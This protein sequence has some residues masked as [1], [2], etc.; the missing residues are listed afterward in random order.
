MNVAQS[1]Q[2]MVDTLLKNQGLQ[3]TVDEASKQLSK[4]LWLFDLN[5]RFL[6]VPNSV[7]PVPEQIA[8]SFQQGTMP[9]EG[10][11][12]IHAE[13]IPDKLWEDSAPV[14]YYNNTL[15]A[16]LMVLAVRT[17]NVPVGFLVTCA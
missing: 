14:R 6:T 3:Y 17:K 5:Y 2:H 11:Q 15:Q 1:T 8:D 10:I 7:F 12:Y 4:P 16:W 9:L 13:K